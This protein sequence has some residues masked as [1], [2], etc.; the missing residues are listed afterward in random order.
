MNEEKKTPTADTLLLKLKEYV[1]FNQ[2]YIRADNLMRKAADQMLYAEAAIHK[3]EKEAIAETMS[4]VPLI[5][6]CI[7]YLE[8]IPESNI[9]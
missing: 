4:A 9:K 3:K 8:S 1:H 2:E 5:L 7:K 6:D